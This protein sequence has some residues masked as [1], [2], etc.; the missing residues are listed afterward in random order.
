MSLRR[1]SGDLHCSQD[2]TLS[3]HPTAMHYDKITT[4]S[5][6]PLIAMHVISYQKIV[7]N[8]DEFI[9]NG[10]RVIF[11]LISDENI[12]QSYFCL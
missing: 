3:N 1:Q 11:I 6:S 4:N 10:N 8:K 9:Q 2:S 12:F 5:F 7:S